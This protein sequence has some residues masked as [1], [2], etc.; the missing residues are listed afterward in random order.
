[1]SYEKDDYGCIVGILF[2]LFIG[3]KTQEA[4]FTEM[5]GFLFWILYISCLYILAY[6]IVLVSKLLTRIAKL[7]GEYKIRN[8]LC[9]HGIKGGDTLN[10]CE[11]CREEKIKKQEQSE[12]ARIE[13]EKKDIIK[14]N[15]IALRNQEIKESTF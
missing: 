15:V 7:K 2:F 8:T 10:K 12:K 9:M 11:A 5:N 6:V 1:M 3:V 14:R 4:F 13:Q